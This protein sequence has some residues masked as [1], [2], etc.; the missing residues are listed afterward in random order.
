MLVGPVAKGLAIIG[1]FAFVGLLYA[2]RWMGAVSSL[3]AAVILGLLANIVTAIFQGSNATSFYFGRLEPM[4]RLPRTIDKPTELLGFR[5]DEIGVFVSV[6]LVF[7]LVDWFL[8]GTFA[9]RARP[10]LSCAA[11]GA[12]D[13]K[14]ISFILFTGWE[15]RW[16][17]YC[18]R[19]LKKLS[20]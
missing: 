12:E 17:S 4:R 19:D 18:R 20:S 8:R 2:G 15:Y 13:R 6:L 14:D 7:L 1:L 11:P 3:V 9:F 5:M 16:G 10:R